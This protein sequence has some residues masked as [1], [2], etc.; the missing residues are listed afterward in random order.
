MP[1]GNAEN[2]KAAAQRKRDAAI[3]RAELALQRLAGDG[4]VITYRGLARAAGV[5]VDFLY[6][7]P[8]RARIDELRARQRN[9]PPQLTA[10]DK[11]ETQSQSSVVRALSVQLTQ[12]RQQHRA[13]LARLERALAA[14]HGENLELRR[15]LGR[16]ATSAQ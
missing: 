6:R 16:H 8:L 13:D 4:N 5:S 7:S 3:N 12:L 14:A 10:S 11:T 2:L 1:R 9:H 15:R